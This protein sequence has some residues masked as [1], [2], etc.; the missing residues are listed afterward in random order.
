[1][2]ENKKPFTAE[3]GKVLK[4]VVNSLYSDKK[5]FLR[6]L[7]SNASDACDKLRYLAVMSPGLVKGGL[8][9]K[10]DI[11]SDEE[12]KTVTISDNGIGMNET[13][14]TNL[15]G[16][17]AKSGTAEFLSNLSGDRQKDAALIGQFGVGFYASFMVADKVEV[18]SK[19]VGEDKAYLWVSDGE[20]GYTIKETTKEG[21]GT[22]ITLHLKEDDKKNAE[23]A[24]IRQLVKHYSDHIAIPIFLGEEKLNQGQSIWSK[25][26]AEVKKEEYIDFYRLITHAFDE[27]L[28]TFHYRA[29]GVIEYTALMF[30]P[31][32]APFDLFQP[33]KKK[34]LR[35]YTN[36]VFIS[37]EVKEL[38]PQYMRYVKGVID[39][40]DLP[41][42]VSREMLQ[43]TP[44]LPKIRKGIVTR[45][46]NELK[47]QKENN[48]EDYKKFWKS[49]GL[50]LKEGLYEDFENQE[51]IADLCLFN[52]TKDENLT[53]FEDYVKAMPKEQ[54][55]IYYLSGEN[56]EMLR[57]NPNIEGAKARGIEVLLLSDPIDEFWPQMYMTYKDKPIKNL[58]NAED[59]IAK[60][61][62]KEKRGKKAGD[63][64]MKALIADVKEILKDEVDEVKT[65][66]RLYNSPVALKAGE[67]D[68]SLQLERLMKKS[69][70]VQSYASKRVLELNPYHPLIA[71]LI[72]TKKDKADISDYVLTLLDMAKIAEGEILKDPL[73]YQNRIC[74][75]MVRVLT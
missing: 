67:G 70:Q 60:L 33:D 23:P 75:M 49:F 74:Q 27:P 58:L 10:I 30:I 37:D 36:N 50:V 65:T 71:K 1:M 59:E 34:T 38:L 20:T 16:S 3:V 56:T 11:R 55:S 19:K 68:M 29:E 24:T 6:E 21:R 26:K 43:T 72:E 25:N 47:K 64:E 7:V 13:D 53:T 46:L 62:L 22:E 2:T 61:P 28:W 14:M 48:L 18:K 42:N 31:T 40:K 39:T 9:F 69:H 44:V 52:Q 35:L 54:K 32:D 45:I 41:L 15:L 12:K 51:K 73:K 17:I 8:D 66:E 63:A 5:I 57:N 4:I